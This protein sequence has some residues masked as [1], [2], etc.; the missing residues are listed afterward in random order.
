MKE[1]LND[2]NW[3]NV[4][5]AAFGAAQAQF[6]AMSQLG[7]TQTAALIAAITTGISTAIAAV[8]DSSK[9]KSSGKPAVSEDEITKAVTIAAASAI[10]PGLHTAAPELVGNVVKEV[11]RVFDRGIRF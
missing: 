1:M 7:A 11:K 9:S 3:G 6:I 10:P 5:M 8:Y 4:L 2:K